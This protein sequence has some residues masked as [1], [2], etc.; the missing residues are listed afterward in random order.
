MTDKA[1]WYLEIWQVLNLDPNSELNKTQNRL[2]DHLIQ[3]CSADLCKA[4]KWDGDPDIWGVGMIASY[5]TLAGLATLYFV[6]LAA[7]G[8]FA[9]RRDSAGRSARRMQRPWKDLSIFQRFV[10]CC[11]ESL[12]TF[13]MASHLFLIAVLSGA[14][15]QLSQP[16]RH[17]D[18]KQGRLHLL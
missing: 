1:A 14:I 9:F 18:D 8:G 12:P 11:S 6:V 2:Y 3:N 13:L 10:G 15:H 7:C 5:F 17:K 16:I 4:L